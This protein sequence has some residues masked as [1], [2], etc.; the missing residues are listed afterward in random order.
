MP[1]D[2]T[3]DTGLLTEENMAEALENEETKEDEN[4]Y[5]PPEDVSLEESHS[6]DAPSNETPD[7]E[8]KT[9]D[10][11]LSEL[12]GEFSELSGIES[13]SQ[14]DGALRYGELRELGLT[15]REAYLATRPRGERPLSSRAH[16]TPAAPR[17]ARKLTSSMP[18]KELLM[19]RELFGDLTDAEIEAL[20]KRVNR[21]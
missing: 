11:D 8:E 14:M 9:L 10:S 6:E 5:T 18:H 13:I 16:L 17:S 7:G 15:P 4:L 12:V 19:A 21:A 1:T 2:N 3:Q 20:Y